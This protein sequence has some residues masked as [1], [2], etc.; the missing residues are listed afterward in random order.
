MSTASVV[1]TAKQ[2]V[3]D[4]SNQRRQYNSNSQKRCYDLSRF[5]QETENTSYLAYAMREM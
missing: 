4:E 1:S 5:M 3:G 2:E